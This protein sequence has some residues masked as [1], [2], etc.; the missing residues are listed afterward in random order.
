MTSLIW[1]GFIAFVAAMVALDLGVFHRKAHEV[2]L[3]EALVWTAV[4]VVLALAFNLLV[5]F[6][7]EESW[8]GW[9]TELSHRLT[10]RQAALEFLTGYVLEKSLSIDNIFIIA[11]I[12]A[13]FRVPREQQHRL[14]VWGVLGAVVLRGVM[15]ASGALLIERFEWIVYIFGALLIGSAAKRL[16]E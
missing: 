7:Y 11:M 12:F 8:L 4:W 1:I 10:G 5:Y 14:L 16:P 13:Y 2:R 3:G 6:L 9:T 15:I